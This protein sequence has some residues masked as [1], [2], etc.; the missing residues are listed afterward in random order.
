M[1]QVPPPQP[2][3]CSRFSGCYFFVCRELDFV[4]TLSVMRPTSGARWGT[5]R[6]APKGMKGRCGLRSGRKR[7]GS[8]PKGARRPF[9]GTAR[10]FSGLVPKN[11]PEVVWFKSHPRN[12]VKKTPQSGVFFRALKIPRIPL[13]LWHQAT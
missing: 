13:Q 7:Q 3:K 10:R 9:S 6:P 2:K 12:H 5:C 1:V 8:A 4:H 11:N